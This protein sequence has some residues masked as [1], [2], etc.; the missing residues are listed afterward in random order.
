MIADE[1]PS[2]VD[3][4]L[5]VLVLFLLFFDECIELTEDVQESFEFSVL[6]SSFLLESLFFSE[7]DLP[8]R[9]KLERIINVDFF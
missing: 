3:T 8:S 1:D 6:D 2:E 7:E 4:S 9:R 5:P